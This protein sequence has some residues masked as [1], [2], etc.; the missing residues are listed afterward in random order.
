MKFMAFADWFRMRCDVGFYLLSYSDRLSNLITLFVNHCTL[1]N[2]NK[3]LFIHFI[4][5]LLN[6]LEMREG[7]WLSA[8][9]HC[10]FSV[11][12]SIVLF[13]S[14]TIPNVN[15]EVELHWNRKKS[16]GAREKEKKGLKIMENT[17]LHSIVFDCCTACSRFPLHSK[18]F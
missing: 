7:G 16:E 1:I 9:P 14:C 6:I 12:F 10:T 3:I 5:V 13:N 8:R 2:I 4:Y 11:H 15:S 18:Q 17:L